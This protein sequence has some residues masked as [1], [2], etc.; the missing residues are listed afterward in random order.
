M[1][2]AHAQV[3][4]YYTLLSVFVLILSILIATKPKATSKYSSVITTL[5]LVFC[6]LFIGWRDWW[7]EE[8]FVDSRRYGE[9][10]LSLEYK[11]SEYA[12]DIGF[13]AL[14]YL[15]KGFGI[16][17]SLFFIICA[18]LYVYPHYIVA[19][20]IS[21][22]YAFIVFLM[23]I[24][25]LVFY[26]YG[27]NGIRNGLATSFL[28]LAFIK[29]KKTIPFLIYGLLAILFH[30][31]A[32][33]PFLTFI[34]ARIY[35]KN[36]KWYILVWLL[37][38]PLSFVVKNLV[39]DF[40]L[41]IEFLSDRAEWYM[42]AEADASKFS[43]VGFRYDFILYS[44]MPIFLGRYFMVKKGFDDQFYRIIYCT[45][46][47]ANTV[48]VLVNAIP[49]S[50]RFAYLSWFLMPIL[51]VYPFIYYPQIKKRFPK[52]ALILFAQLCFLL[53]V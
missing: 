42:L 43:H 39:S 23:I 7:V 12:K 33:L 11:S 35:N 49:F 50:N 19:K 34:C 31:S 13:Y 45:Y 40:I 14:E 27:V 15:C 36:I 17:V 41:A 10:Y 30:K 38:I 18:I 52:I 53:V 26:N 29:Y 25:S 51:I 16:S 20:S 32:L 4:I 47:L 37:A 9:A 1:F 5:L 6:V 44:A 8:V 22:E 3:T 21:N 46:L 48:F 28:L 2:E 24:T